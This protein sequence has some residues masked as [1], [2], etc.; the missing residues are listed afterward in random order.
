MPSIDPCNPD[1]AGLRHS[2]AL[3]PALSSASP[4]V[5]T[6][7][8][9][10][11]SFAALPAMTVSGVVI[12]GTEP[13]CRILQVDGGNGVAG[14]WALTGSAAATPAVGAHVTVTGTVRPDLR[15]PCGRVLVVVP[16]G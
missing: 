11:P 2:S 8:A 16:S 9:P 4:P 12:E 7:T 10:G 5:G 14:R 1:A 13:S 15:S 6:A 3:S